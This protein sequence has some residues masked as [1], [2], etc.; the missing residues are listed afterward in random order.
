MISFCLRAAWRVKGCR[1]WHICAYAQAFP[2]CEGCSGRQQAKWPSVSG[3]L[4]MRWWY[5]LWGMWRREFPSL[6]WWIPTAG[7]EHE[8]KLLEGTVVPLVLYILCII[9]CAQ[10]MKNKLYT[11]VKLK[12][13]WFFTTRWLASGDVM[14]GRRNAVCGSNHGNYLQI[15]SALL[16]IIYFKFKPRMTLKELS[17]KL[18]QT[19][20]YS[21]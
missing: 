5:S 2:V 4:V 12:P 8:S 3:A 10:V 7:V 14:V 17:P 9:S 13:W 19:W 11:H 6:E 16:H 21:H 1:P 15:Q 18:T 20:K